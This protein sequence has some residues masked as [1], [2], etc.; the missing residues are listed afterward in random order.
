MVT[1]G[2]EEGAEGGSDVAGVGEYD[3]IGD[4]LPASLAGGGNFQS[5]VHPISMRS[6]SGRDS[7]RKRLCG[8]R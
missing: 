3:R 2:F 8:S 7:G 4:D 5:C 1:E 6:T